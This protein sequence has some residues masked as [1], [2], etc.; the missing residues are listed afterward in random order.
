VRTSEGEGISGV[1]LTGLPGN[2]S[3]TTDG[4]YSST[5]DSGWSGTV[6]PIK[7][8]YSFEPSSA[9]Y[10]SVSSGQTQDYTG[11]KTVTRRDIDNKIREFKEGTATQ[12]EVI[13]LINSYME[14]P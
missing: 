10:S 13:D 9:D 8:G 4:S 11:T 5:V 7:V 12:Q 14:G 6:T 1:V 2:P 3:T